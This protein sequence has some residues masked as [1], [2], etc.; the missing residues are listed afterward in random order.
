MRKI[1]LNT[2]LFASLAL[3]GPTTG[4]A[5]ITNHVTLDHNNVSCILTD[6]G[7]FFTDVSSTNAA[8]EVPKGDSVSS[9][10]AGSFLVGAQDPM[11]Q[12][13]F[14]GRKYSLGGS[15]SS[16]HSG[17]IADPFY[18]NTSTYSQL[19]QNALWKVSKAVIDSHQVHFQTAG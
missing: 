2:L 13:Y 16:F 7:G 19:Y 14:S 1:L 8:Y 5:Q 10:F 17:P 4:R 9:I 15:E 11:W 3:F 12:I 18:Y 6:E